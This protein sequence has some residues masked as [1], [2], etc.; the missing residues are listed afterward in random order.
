[1]EMRLRLKQKKKTVTDRIVADK[2]AAG[3]IWTAAVRAALS[4]ALCLCAALRLPG[5]AAVVSAETAADAQGG[6]GGYDAAGAQDGADGYETTAAQGG[7]ELVFLLDASGSMNTQDK[8]RLVIDAIRQ[9]MYSLP[10]DYQTGLVAYNTG[11]EASVAPGSDREE[12]D[13]ALLGVTYGG[14]TNAGLGLS[15]A[16]G[17]F[18]EADNEKYIIMVSDGEID[19]PDREERE[20]S[21]ELYVAASEAAKEKGVRIFMAAIGSELGAGM[22]IFDGAEL[23]DGAIYWEGQSGTAAQIMERIVTERLH[24]PMQELGVT[25]AGGG[26]VHAAIPEHADRVR[27]ILTAE[28]DISDAAAE[29]T[30]ESGR[31]VAGKRFVAVDM[32]RPS[33]GVADIRFR[34]EDISGVRAYMLVEY[35]AKPFLEAAY[36]IEEIPRSEEEIKKKLPPSYEHFADITIWLADTAGTH[37]N[38]WQQEKLQGQTI[39]YTLN[40]TPCEGVIEQ[41]QIRATIPADG[42]GAVEITVDMGSQTELYTIE[43]PVSVQLIKYPDPAPPPAPDY[44]PLW[45]AALLFGAAVLIV[46]LWR[47]K[48]KNTTVIYMAPPPGKAER[49]IE[50]KNS[51]YS[52]RLAMYVVRT[53]DGRDIPPQTYRLFGQPGGRLTLDKILTSCGIKFGRIGAEDIIFYPGPDHTLIMMDQSERCTVMRGSEI[54]K[55]GMGY[56]VCYQEKITIAF[57]D[58]MTEMEIHYKSLKPSERETLKLR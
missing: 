2:T 7:A 44:R 52:G 9:M 43:Q 19:M 14:Y 18:S 49:K 28:A 25:D 8:D 50:T 46:I 38:L 21:R 33:G 22:H 6:A 57:E 10:S 58:E 20:R 27:M 39:C 4:L 5:Q 40:G 13:D 54:M 31:T 53:M 35:S 37:E 15:E 11:L 32:K 3:K 23:T 34:T 47:I 26:A 24:F 56:P 45:A 30:A 48:K 42:I 1:M 17:L 51:A 16:V 12:L 41:G 29:Y 36:R 55:K